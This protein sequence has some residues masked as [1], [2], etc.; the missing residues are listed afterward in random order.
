MPRYYNAYVYLAKGSVDGF[1]S[2]YIGQLIDRSITGTR[3][4]RCLDRLAEQH[5]TPKAIVRGN[6]TELTSK[7]MFAGYGRKT[8]NCI[9]SGLANEA[10]VH[11]PNA[12]MQVAG[13]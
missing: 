11:L 12:F 5:A 3:L 13:L 10:R 6:G 1:N 8:S 2:E 9:S 7:A 4:A